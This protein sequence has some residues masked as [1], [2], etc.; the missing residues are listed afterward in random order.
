MPKEFICVPS[1]N[2]TYEALIYPNR[3]G[4]HLR[5]RRH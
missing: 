5:L 3:H 2:P 4:L 1:R